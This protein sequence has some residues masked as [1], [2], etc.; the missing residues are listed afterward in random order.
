M[1]KRD[2]RPLRVE[3]R[4]TRLGGN[5]STEGE[6]DGKAME[7]TLETLHSFADLL[8]K[9][10]AENIFAVATGVLREA[11]NGRAFI[12]RVFRR[13]GLSLRLVSGEEE[14]RLMLKGVLWSIKKRVHTQLVADIGGWSTEILWVEGNEPIKIQSLRLG[15]VGLSEKFL[16]DDPPGPQE[17]ESMERHTEGILKKIRE[18]FQ[19]EGL[20]AYDL[21]PDLVGTAG[22][23]TTL[24]AIDQ[25]LRTYD[26]QKINGHRIPRQ[27]LEKIY[28][29]L[30]S[31]PIQERR[32]VPGLEKGREDLIVAGVVVVLRL[33][34]IFHLPTLVV[35]DSGLLEGVLLDGI[36]QMRNSE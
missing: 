27:V 22:T 23:M 18:E 34:E 4:I 8:Q 16:Q 30:R 24:A 31:L 10:G 15:T 20:E 6:L 26:P 3:R 12:E 11:I 32:D 14:A 21:H 13:T 7:R 1:G 2:F 9:E 36:A 35:V 29:H 33:M 17:L 5:F 28:H 19:K 25:G